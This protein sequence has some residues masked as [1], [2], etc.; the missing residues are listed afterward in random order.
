M[1]FSFIDIIFL[2]LM[3]V[4]FLFVLSSYLKLFLLKLVY[5]TDDIG[6]ASENGK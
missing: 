4:F 2:L 1:N 5:V 6:V 3:A